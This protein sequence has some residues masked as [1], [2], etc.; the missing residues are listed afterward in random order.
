VIA[1]DAMRATLF[2]EKNGKSVARNNNLP[3]FAS[4]KHDKSFGKPSF[5]FFS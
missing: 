3:I 5:G 4:S 2:S 1:G